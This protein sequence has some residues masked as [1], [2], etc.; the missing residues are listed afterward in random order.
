MSQSQDATFTAPMG[1][2]NLMN[3]NHRDSE[4]IT[5]ESSLINEVLLPTGQNAFKTRHDE[6]QPLSPASSSQRLLN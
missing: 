5:G 6:T 3:I 2:E 1:E 4:S